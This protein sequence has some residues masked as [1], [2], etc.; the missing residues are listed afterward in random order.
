MARAY[1]S[2]RLGFV[3]RKSARCLV[4]GNRFP[5]SDS[6]FSTLRRPVLGEPYETYSDRYRYMLSTPMSRLHTAITLSGLL[7]GLA[8]GI[9]LANRLDQVALVAVFFPVTCLAWWLG[10][11]LQ[12]PLERIPGKCPKCRYDLRKLKDNRCPECGTKFAP[13]VKPET[14]VVEDAGEPDV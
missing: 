5:V 9:V 1:T 2:A 11:F 12:P 3:R 8:L 14:N 7:G 13:D 4:C 6:A 10:R